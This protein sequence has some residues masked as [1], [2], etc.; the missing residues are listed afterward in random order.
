LPPPPPTLTPLPYTTL[1]RSH[2]FPRQKSLQV[3]RHFSRG[4]IAVLRFFFQRLQADVLQV[5]GYFWIPPPWQSRILFADQP[6]LLAKRFPVKRWASG[7]QLVQ[8]CA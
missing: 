4:R 1:F 7:Q 2:F 5:P 8:Y 6:H 3:I